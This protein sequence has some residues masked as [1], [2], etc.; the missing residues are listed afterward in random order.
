[1][2][3]KTVM[4]DCLCLEL[5]GSL[6]QVHLMHYSTRFGL[7]GHRNY[8]WKYGGGPVSELEFFFSFFVVEVVKMIKKNLVI[9]AVFL[10]IR[11]FCHFEETFCL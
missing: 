7:N 11:H 10:P 3:T 4:L 8:L 6:D 5:A 2:M 1:M 9:V